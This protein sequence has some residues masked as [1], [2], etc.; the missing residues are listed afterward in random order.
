MTTTNINIRVD[1]KLK[2]QAETLFSD[3]GMNM[4]T[5]I[6]MFLKSAVSHNGLPF[7]VKRLPVDKKF[8]AVEDEG[9]Q[10]PK[11]MRDDGFVLQNGQLHHDGT[12]CQLI[13]L[14]VPEGVSFID[15]DCFAHSERLRKVELPKSLKEIGVA[16]F[17]D[18]RELRSVSIEDGVSRIRKL[19][20]FGCENLS[21]INIPS[22]VTS[23]GE[24]AFRDCR[25]LRRLLIPGSVSD[26]CAE[27]FLN[28]PELTIVAEIDS[29]AAAYAK[30][31]GFDLELIMPTKRQSP[32]QIV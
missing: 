22:T 5:A 26:I 11:K 32:I 8:P 10:L 3:L 24:W 1:S 19:T 9:Y 31:F 4:S 16:A 29:F 17:A 7:E 2:E 12:D 14:R 23:I 25:D 13:D 30:K 15:N 27:S 6:I 28:C 18:C 21:H 20:F